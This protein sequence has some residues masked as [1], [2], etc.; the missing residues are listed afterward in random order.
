MNGCVCSDEISHQR[1]ISVG[2]SLCHVDLHS[3]VEDIAQKR[4]LL[5]AAWLAVER[6]ER[7]ELLRYVAVIKPLIQRQDLTAL[8]WTNRDE[9]ETLLAIGFIWQDEAA[10]ALEL[11]QAVVSRSAAPRVRLVLL[12]V[13]RYACWKTRRLDV[14]YDLS[15]PRHYWGRLNIPMLKIINLSIEAAA[16]AEQLR[17]KLAERNARRAVELAELTLGSDANTSLLSRCVLATVA[18]E[19]GGLDE[20]LALIRGSDAAIDQYGSA[21]TTQWAMTLATRVAIAK[22]NAKHA[23]AVIRRGQ[24]VSRQRGWK[25]LAAHLAEHEITWLIKEKNLRL[26][27]QLLTRVLQRDPSG[28]QLGVPI[29]EATWPMESARLRLAFANGDLTEAADGFT[30]LSCWLNERNQGTYAVRF[31]VLAAASLFHGGHPEEACAGLLRA[32]ETGAAAGLFRTFVDELEFIAPCLR[33]IRA[34]M[35]HEL[36]HLNAYINAILAARSVLIASSANSVNQDPV[37]TLSRREAVVLHLV[38]KGYSNK[39]IAR[40]LYITPETVKSHI[41]RITLKLSS[42]TRAEAVALGKSF[43]I[44]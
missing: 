14:F 44:I 12:T 15:M 31:A 26:A 25:A 38:S 27:T 10:R 4:E 30:R 9:L 13:I 20:A 7:D 11:A 16:E 8:R 23:L 41:K 22:G 3:G 2:K 40:E 24:V 28:T 37:P 42:K 43:G 29:D 39:T 21:D 6:C 34:S 33:R 35:K 32:L 5:D 17:L 1:P 19:M 18:Y 36:G